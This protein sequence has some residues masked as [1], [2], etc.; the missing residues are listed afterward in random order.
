MNKRA[1][2]LHN[3]V[4]GS[5]Q[6]FPKENFFSRDGRLRRYG[7]GVIAAADYGI[8]RHIFDAPGEREAY[9]SLVREM[10]RR[11]LRVIPGFGI[12]A[13]LYAGLMNLMFRRMSVRERL[14]G[15]SFFFNSP[16]ARKRL[17]AIIQE[18]L[19][20]DRPVILILGSTP[21]F[22]KKRRGVTLYRMDNDVPEAAKQHVAAHFVTVTG[23]Y[24]DSQK[25]MLEVYSWGSRY[26]MSADEYLEA[27]RYTYPFSNRV[28]RA[29]NTAIES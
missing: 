17:L 1:V 7:C 24:E 16:K 15:V 13:Y 19:S 5:Q 27:A 12:S 18:Q 22:F 4:A 3:Y 8:Y 29:K 14:G 6:W 28:Y 20:A 10:E 11:F 25:T 23:I 9:L 26:L 21:F 2:L